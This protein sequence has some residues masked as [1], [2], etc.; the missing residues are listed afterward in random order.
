MFYFTFT[1]EAS[2]A[3]DYD[4]ME[5]PVD[6]P[7]TAEEQRLLSAFQIQKGRSQSLSTFSKDNTTT[8]GFR[9]TQPEN[10][11]VRSCFDQKNR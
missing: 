11:E 1:D 3:L 6:A 8:Q 10:N 5:D 2:E 7:P 4:K 9:F